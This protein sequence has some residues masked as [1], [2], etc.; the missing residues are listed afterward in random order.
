MDIKLKI[1]QFSF[2]SYGT[3]QKC[4]KKFCLQR[5]LD[6][7]LKIPEPKRF[8]LKNDKSLP[9]FADIFN[10]FICYMNGCLFIEN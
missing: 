5:P 7:R 4:E 10:T 6:L 2:F 1:G 3:A 9:P 8:S